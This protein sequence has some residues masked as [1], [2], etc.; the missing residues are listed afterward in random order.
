[1]GDHDG[2]VRV[3][4]TLFADRADG[5]YSGI[6]LTHAH[7]NMPATFMW[8]RG[9]ADRPIH[10]EFR[11]PPGLAWRLA[12]Q[13]RPTATPR[14]FT[15]PDLAYFMDSPTEF[16]AFDVREWTVP[17]GQGSRTIRIALH[18][19]G[20]A[21]EFDAYSEMAKKVVR[22]QIA[23]FG[24]A[25]DYDFGTYTFIADYL[26][27]VSGDGMEHR[28]STILTST[29]PLATGAMA[30]L[31]TLSHEFFHAWN[32]ERIRP[33]SLE[34]FDF[35]ESN[36]SGELWLA[37]GF[38]SYYDDLFIRRAGLMSDE[39]YAQGLAGGLN[40][41]VNGAGRRYFSAVEMSMQ[42]PFVDAAAS[43]DPSNRDNTF[44]SYYTWGSVIGLGLDLSLRSHFPGVT[45][46]DYMRALWLRF[47]KT[48]VPYTLADL[49]DVLTEV[50][51][52]AAFANDFFDRYITGRDVAD[53]AALLSN[54]GILLRKANAG[55]AWLGP[56]AFAY[57]DGMAIVAS[58]TLAGTPLY[59]AGVER[60]DR[61]ISI[62]GETIVDAAALTRLLAARRP[63]DRVAITY[64]Q[65][66]ATRTA[67]VALAEDPQ[68]EVMT[69]E[70][71]GMTVT[72]NMRRFRAAWL[73]SRSRT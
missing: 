32:V 60:G 50:T 28:N 33:R 12:T 8:A 64:E 53:Y 40:A 5:T 18:H 57:P 9:E 26:P 43:I 4:Y 55:A 6:D 23:V 22:E 73:G 39:D 51:R 11:P 46:D 72:D 44:I 20:T 15:A 47:G 61:I 54:A 67:E 1:V 38:T 17:A 48:E 56:T 14:A 19:L 30:N 36:M 37:E 13:L 62:A 59:E 3:S 42:A 66:G 35:E 63:G 29:R 34:P 16:G 69:Y 58:A 70:R 49:R 27:W 71:A 10:I 24:E 45:L 25:P 65:R 31:G 7:L 68:L 52:D 2:T 41:V 21:A